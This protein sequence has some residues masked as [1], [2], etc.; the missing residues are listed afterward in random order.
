[1]EGGKARER[2]EK[3]KQFNRIISQLN[4]LHE[5]GFT[6]DDVISGGPDAY[7][8]LRRK[9]KKTGR[10]MLPAI[11][12]VTTGRQMEEGTGLGDWYQNRYHGEKTGTPIEPGARRRGVRVKRKP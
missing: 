12:D 7:Q 1:M 5:A 4:E 11:A 10:Q 9:G 8:T 3:K 6:N 2:L